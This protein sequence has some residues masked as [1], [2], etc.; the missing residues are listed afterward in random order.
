MIT[1][2]VERTRSIQG[3][4]EVENLLHLP[5]TPAQMHE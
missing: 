5:G 2:L 4:R 1:E 3:V